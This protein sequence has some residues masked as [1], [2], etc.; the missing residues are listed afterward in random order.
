MFRVVA[1]ADDSLRVDTESLVQVLGDIATVETFP[2]KRAYGPQELEE[3]VRVLISADALLVRS[4][5][6]SAALIQQLPN[7]KIIATHGSGFDVID[8]EAASKKGIWVTNTPGAN[9]ADVAEYTL[10]LMLSLLRD[11][12][13]TIHKL[14]ATHGWDESRVVGSRL[15]GK[16]IGILGFGAIGQR[17]AALCRAFGADVLVHSRG[18]VEGEREGITF[19]SPARLFAEAEILTLHLPLTRETRHLLDEKAFS[20]MRNGVL[21]INTARGEIVDIEALESAL[22][23]GKLAGAALDMLEKEPPDF[24]RR[25]FAQRQVLITPHAAGSTH[26]CLTQ[27]AKTAG[28]DIR[29]IL[30]GKKP[31]HAVNQPRLGGF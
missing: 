22:E 15:S 31:L 6:V 30:L 19:V 27:I 26:E 21:L 9:A 5:V 23:S 13:G 3:T 24:S 1:T 16:A 4:G 28:M 14:R 10:G 29:R 18:L 7:L 2:L 20:Q 8:V 12:P 25:I 17:V 11:L